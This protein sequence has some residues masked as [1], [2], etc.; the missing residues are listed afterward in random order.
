MRKQLKW[1]MLALGAHLTA[2][3]GAADF[4]APLPEVSIPEVPAPEASPP[5]PAD[6]DIEA[7]AAGDTTL[8]TDALGTGWVDWSW[9]T[10]NL[11]VTSPVASGTRAISVTFGPWTGLY[12]HNAGVPTAGLQS[13]EFQVHGGATAD[14][15]LAAYATVAGKARPT[16]KVNTYCDGGSIKAGAWTR[17]RVPLSA[18]GVVNVTMDGIVLQEGAGR[19]LPVMYFDNVRLLASAV[20]APTGV[21]ATGSASDVALT[22]STVSG[23]SGYNVYR[24]TSQ[25]GTY[26]KLTTA[27]VSTASYRD[28]AVTSG[29]TYWYAVAAVGPAGEGPR[30]SAVSATVR[31]PVPTVSIAVSPTSA[32]L[33]PGA[34]RAFTATVTGSTNTGVTWSVSQGGGTVTNGGVY[35]APQTP[36]TYQ[37]IATSQADT[38]KKATATVTVTAPNPGGTGKWVSGYYTGWNADLYPPEKVDFS[39][40]THIMV[41]RV[42]PRPDGTVSTQF[43]NDNGPQIARTLATRAHAAGRK[44]IIMVGGAGE[45][46]NWVA[47]ANSANRAKFVQSLLTAM[48]TF[49][50]DGLDLDWEPV[51][52]ADKPDLLALVKALRAARPNMLLTFPI[53]WINANVP[54]DADPWFANL[55]PYVD[56]INVMSYEMVGPWEGWQSWYTSALYGHSGNRPTSVTASLNGWVSAGIPKAKLG[57]G[58]PFYGMAWRNITGPYQNFTHWS[59]YVG[60]DNSFSYKKIHQLSASGKYNWD[61]VAAA[62]YLTFSTPV[63]D[64]TVRWISYDSPQAIAAKG[65]Y[66]R[67]NGFGGTII[68]SINQGCIDP[69]T[70]A[71]PLLDAVKSAF[72]Q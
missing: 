51:E 32:S 38:T 66:T 64:G 8:Y 21:S 24:A 37:V 5:A 23:A 16:V 28:A 1:F 46:A 52:A 54:T 19:S 65:A 72:L 40:M 62:S 6:N 48:D 61:A 13:L 68:W 4:S 15:A 12:F 44:A 42:T 71:N 10:R 25:A 31:A 29:A 39:A 14:P 36:G 30:S 60:S 27:P 43:D 69:A 47:A 45:H 20:T 58:I 67:D 11:A 35:T 59:D 49:G 22:W 53:G 7:T 26:T 33:A 17:C 55:V 41:G 56:Q 63:E 9:A 3:G 2:C 18:L 70:G 50:Y 57:M 34:T